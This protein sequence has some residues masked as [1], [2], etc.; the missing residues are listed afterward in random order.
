LVF[1]VGIVGDDCIV[2]GMAQ[3]NGATSLHSERRANW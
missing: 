2:V 3:N 1:G